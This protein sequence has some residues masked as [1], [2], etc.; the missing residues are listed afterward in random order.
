MNWDDDFFDL[1]SDRPL[2]FAELF[3][4]I[5]MGLIVIAIMACALFWRHA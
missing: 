3:A 2:T 5:A 4:G 1:S